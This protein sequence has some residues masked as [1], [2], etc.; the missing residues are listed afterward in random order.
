MEQKKDKTALV[1]V[2]IVAVVLL[3]LCGCLG[4]AVYL[5]GQAAKQVSNEIPDVVAT[6]L[7]EGIEDAVGEPT[8]TPEMLRPETE[9]PADTLQ[10][11]EEAVV[12]E[13]DLMDLACRLHN[14][15]GFP[16]IVPS[17]PYHTGD[18]QKF[19]V[20]NV[21][22]DR[23]FQIDATLQAVTPHAYFWVQD[24]VSFSQDD[25]NA[26]AET[27]EN[28]I[29]P[30]DR[31][32]FGSEWTPGVDDDPHVYILYASDL[33]YSLG[34]Y[35]SSVDEYPPQA[36]EYSNA[37][38][39]FVI[40]TRYADFADGDADVLSHEFQHMIHW[41]RDFNET[42]WLNEGFSVLAE[43]LN[44]YKPGFEY[45]YIRDTDMQLNDWGSEVSQNSPHY[46]G[47]FLFADY[48]LSRFGD[49]A[50]QRLVADKENGM[51]SVD[52]VL[53]SIGAKNPITGA[54]LSA[55]D[56]VLQWMIANY[57][58]D[59]SVDDGI[60]AYANYPDAPKASPTERI[61]ECPAEERYDVYQ[62]GADYIEITC[63]GDYTLSFTGS[64]VANLLPEDAH[65][66][67]YAF[68]SN[69]GDESDMTLTREFD[70]SDVSNVTLTFWTW[71]DLEK[72]YDYLYLEV[73]ED[74][75]H[76]D[77]LVTPSGTD[78][79]PSGNSYGWGYNG[80]T[81]GWIEETVDLSAYAGKKVYLRFEYVTD[82]AVN[83]KGFLL[84]DL[85]IP[86]IGYETDFE[87]DDGGWEGAGFVRVEN[88]LPQ[89]FRLALIVQRNN[90]ETT[91][92]F[93][94]VGEN[95]TANVPLSLNAGDRATLVVTGVTRFS[96]E[97]AAY[98]VEIH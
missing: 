90:G 43:F 61:E 41:Y 76:W 7:A 51:E 84:D 53:A 54:P 46:G 47:S 15:C 60:Y 9:V 48:F 85:S 1:V 33:G 17:G 8:A 49:E 97:K 13:N 22:T 86:E 89:E 62:Y 20:T 57:L 73:S 50:T 5:F 74:G 42:S 78:E 34:G 55:D 14:L 18:H 39:M 65:S 87:S 40:H 71:Y 63:E 52:D 59:P 25:L 64:M 16:R 28:K 93:L 88:R 30:T 21:D 80:S 36:H 75:E 32:F 31:A 91:V 82:A 26:L 2:S 79:D 6:T 70:F 29:Y 98:T 44:G 94:P 67:K 77:I 96:H 11:L 83:G 45:A 35:F 4:G 69:R 56:L 58:Q 38:E 24:G 95:Q 81:E 19:W 10:A 12:P 23:S 92:D 68:W 72:N 66:G 27:F 3:L 37:H